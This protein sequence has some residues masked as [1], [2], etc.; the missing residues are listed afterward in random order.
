MGTKKPGRYYLGPLPVH[1]STLHLILS[2][3]TGHV[4]PQYR[5]DCNNY[6]ETTKST[7]FM[8]ES[9]WQVKERLVKRPETPDLD[10]RPRARATNLMNAS[11]SRDPDGQNGV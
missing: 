1:A 4:S 8:L 11:T 9:E 3:Q 6:F 2:I 5:V 7:D 10:P